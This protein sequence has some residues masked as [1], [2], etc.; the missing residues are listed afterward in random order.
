MSSISA[1]A[2]AWIIFSANVAAR[3]ARQ[4]STAIISQTCARTRQLKLTSCDRLFP[5]QDAMPRGGFGNLIA[6]PLQKAPRENG[7]SEMAGK[8]HQSRT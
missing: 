6:L 2:H 8:I 1:S 3:D 4:L 5:N 7:G